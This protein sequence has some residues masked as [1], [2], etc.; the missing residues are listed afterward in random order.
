MRQIQLPD[1]TYVNPAEIGRFAIEK[2]FLSNKYLLKIYSRGGNKIGIISRLTL[3]QAE[4]EKHQYEKQLK[5]LHADISAYEE[6][7][8]AGVNKGKKS[9]YETG[10]QNL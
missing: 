9:G 4:I 2:H 5:I 8:E 3:E 7:F 10:H 1:G 6:G